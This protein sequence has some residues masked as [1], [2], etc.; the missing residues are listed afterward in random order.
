MTHEVL[1]YYQYTRLA[2]PEAFARG[3]RE[4]CQK[5]DLR[6][7]VLVA[8]EGLNGT[9]SGP[10][11]STRAYREWMHASPSFSNMAF[12]VDAA[13]G[14]VFR[15]LYV[16]ARPEIVT[17]GLGS[18]D[19][20]PRQGGGERLSP[21]EF[22]RAMNDP[23]AVLLDGRN[24]Y[25]SDLGHFEGAVCPPVENFRDFPDWIRG[26][27]AHLK[28]K[29]I[30]TYCTGGIR[31]EKLSAFLKQEGFAHVYQLDGGIVSYGKDPEV[32]GRRFKGKCYVFDERIG[33]ECN[34]AED[35]CT[36]SRC[37]E[38][39]ELS[40]RYVNCQRP[41]CNKRFFLSLEGEQKRGHRFCPECSAGHDDPVAIRSMASG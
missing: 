22:L 20:D 17:L 37:V 7:R 8:G 36:V 3:H 15:K 35:R 31:C 18:E 2:D 29:K 39:G 9:L 24:D 34:H 5:L 19:V 21:P 28:D 23:D 27:M 4:V 41:E 12:K 32:Q 33:V 26:N 10:V 38:T 40:D 11:A 1:L 16:R 13:E 6:G 25:E 30:L 14:H